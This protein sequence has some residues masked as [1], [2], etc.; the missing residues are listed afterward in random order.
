M[1]FNAGSYW[2]F[3]QDYSPVMGKGTTLLCGKRNHR[4]VVPVVIQSE[5]H[6]YTTSY[7]KGELKSLPLKFI[8]HP[9]MEKWTFDGEDFTSRSGAAIHIQFLPKEQ[10]K[11]KTVTR[12]R[13]F[14]EEF[15]PVWREIAQYPADN[16]SSIWG[17]S[18]NLPHKIK[19]GM[20]I[21]LRRY[22]GYV[23]GC[24]H[25]P[26][27]KDHHRGVVFFT[28]LEEMMVF[29]LTHGKDGKI[30]SYPEGDM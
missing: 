22:V 28:D 18:R 1:D 4:G 6:T 17:A 2:E 27:G 23:E 13:F 24:G 9:G 16:L 12:L 8:A 3:T 19:D 30:I 10:L 21:L 20:R 25:L 5:G 15:R 29:C 7:S 14:M 11:D 26:K